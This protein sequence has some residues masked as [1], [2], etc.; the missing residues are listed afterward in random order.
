MSN[1]I[2]LSGFPS[3][4]P[5]YYVPRH[6]SMKVFPYPHTH[7]HLTALASFYARASSLHRTEG[8][9]SR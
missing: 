9:P 6:V 3:A 4:R 7:S 8:L 5:L 1:V 2:P